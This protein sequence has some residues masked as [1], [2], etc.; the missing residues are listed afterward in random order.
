[1]DKH[2]EL[3]WRIATDE[4]SQGEDNG[5]VNSSGEE[6]LGTSEWLRC[7]ERDMSFILEACNNYERLIS[8]RD[9]WKSKFI[10]Q[11]KDLDCEL[12]D[13]NGTIW[14]HAKKLQEENTRL[15]SAMKKVFRIIEDE[16]PF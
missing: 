1:M 15:R 14:D 6:V 13:P 5:I 4:E 3:P 7:S 2:T 8:E 12:M 9:D 10:Q 16:T 11:N